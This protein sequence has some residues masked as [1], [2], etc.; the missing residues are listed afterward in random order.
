MTL[1]TR[2]RELP[3]AAREAREVFDVS[4]AGDTVIATLAVMLAAG[5]EPATPRCASPTAPRGIVVG[6]LGTAVVTLQ[7]ESASPKARMT[8]YIVTGAAGFIG[9]KLVRGAEPPRRDAT[10]SPS[11]TSRRPTS[12]GTSPTARSPTTSTSRASSRGCDSAR[13]R[14]RRPCCTRAPAPTRW[15]PTAAT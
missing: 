1:F 5:A 14:G 6:K 13:G 3:H 10:S 15:R 8:Y 9:S 11:T 7:A 2:R 4:G 12:S